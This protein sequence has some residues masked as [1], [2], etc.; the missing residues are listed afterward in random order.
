MSN[1]FDNPSFLTWKSW[2]IEVKVQMF[3]FDNPNFQKNKLKNFDFQLKIQDF[4]WKTW[5][6]DWKSEIFELLEIGCQK[7][8]MFH[9]NPSF[10]TCMLK[11]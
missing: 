3:Y 9:W 2:I 6:I 1:Y 11:I 8:V 10:S 5:I 7:S 4:P